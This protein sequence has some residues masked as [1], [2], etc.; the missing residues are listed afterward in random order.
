MGVGVPPDDGT[1]DAEAEDCK[2]LTFEVGVP[3]GAESPLVAG[4]PFDREL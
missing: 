2:E 1:W 4:I 3:F